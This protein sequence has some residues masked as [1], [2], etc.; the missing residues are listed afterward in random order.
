[1][2]EDNES[3]EERRE[4]LRQEEIKKTSSSIHGSNLADLV[5][6]IGWKGALFL[7]VL[8]ILVI[9]LFLII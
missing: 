9:L 2:S 6:G 7:I 8:L 4:R 3:P 5:G 1:M